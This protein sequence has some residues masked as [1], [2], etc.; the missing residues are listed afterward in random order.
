MSATTTIESPPALGTTVT[1]IQ[2]AITLYALVM[3]AFMITGGTA[4]GR[5]GRLRAD[6]A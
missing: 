1:G 3:V 4:G 2:T 6:P 5:I